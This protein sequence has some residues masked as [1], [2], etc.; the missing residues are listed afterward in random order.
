MGRVAPGRVFTVASDG[1]RK[2]ARTSV[3]RLVVRVHSHACEGG[4]PC[5]SGQSSC[6][7]RAASLTLS[8]K[9]WAT[10]LPHTRS[11]SLERA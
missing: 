1:P 4:E 3:W 11:C 9:W 10:A 2:R 8:L 5:P 6:G 7:A